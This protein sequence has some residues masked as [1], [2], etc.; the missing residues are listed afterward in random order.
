MLLKVIQLHQELVQVS[1]IHHQ[2]FIQVVHAAKDA[3]LVLRSY[4]L[5]LE[6]SEL[7]VQKRLA[8]P[9]DI[10]GSRIERQTREHVH[11]RLEDECRSSET[12]LG[13]R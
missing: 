10:K 12:S 7:F 5:L 11:R 8:F 6:Y 3:N 1:G 2:L 4:F 13:D 9:E